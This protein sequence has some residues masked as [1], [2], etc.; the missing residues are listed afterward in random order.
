[1]LFLTSRPE[2]AVIKNHTAF[3]KAMLESA[4]STMGQTAY[5]EMAEDIAYSHH[6][7][8]DG[9]DRGYPDHPA[10]ESIPL[11]ARIMS[12]ADVLDALISKRPY[13]DEM[14]LDEAI[15]IITDE[16]NTHFDPEVVAALLR[17]KDKV[18]DV[19]E[20]YSE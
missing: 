17:I 11:A 7:W 10:G 8:W 12:V 14:S 13:K 1:M 15:T 5:L 19:V 4:K 18:R 9:G 20:K 3:G 16:S 6:E 2:F